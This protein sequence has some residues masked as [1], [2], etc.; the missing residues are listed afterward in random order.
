V[1]ADARQAEGPGNVF[2]ANLGVRADAY[3]SVGGFR[4]LHT[5]EDHDLWHRLGSAG[6]RLCFAADALVTTSSR[7]RGRATGGLADLLRYLR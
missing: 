7:L 1:L 2:G 5:G 3:T 4:P 6:Y